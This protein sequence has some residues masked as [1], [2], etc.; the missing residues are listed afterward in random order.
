[1]KL[2]RQKKFDCFFVGGILNVH[3]CNHHYRH[4]VD[5][6]IRSLLPNKGQLTDLQ[7]YSV[8]SFQCSTQSKEP[9]PHDEIQ[10]GTI[11]LVSAVVYH[12]HHHHPSGASGDNYT[13]LGTLYNYY[14]D[15]Y[16]LH[17][18]NFLTNIC[19]ALTISNIATL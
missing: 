15:I 14:S 16:I 19:D 13:Q 12:H 4:R 2:Q 9:V 18:R 8:T 10:L 5:N 3:R 6:L 17:F 7:L 11:N 1:M